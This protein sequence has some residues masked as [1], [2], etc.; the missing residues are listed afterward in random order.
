MSKVRIKLVS[1]G[2][3]PIEF[4]STKVLH[5]KSSTFEIVDDIDNYALRCDSDIAN[6]WAFSDQLVKKQLP[7]VFDA[8]FLIALVNV[9]IENNYYSRRLAN[10]QIVFTFYE[11]KEILENDNIPLEN[12]VFRILYEYTLL[13]KKSGNKIPA[14]GDTYPSFTH[15]ETRGC[16]FDMN[17]I[18]KDLIAS[19]NKPNI[20][21]ECQENLKREKVSN[22]LIRNTQKD[23]KKIKRDLYYR[24][25]SFIK[26]H[27]IMSF[28]ISATFALLLGIT[29]SVIASF[30]F[31]S[32]KTTQTHANV[33]GASNAPQPTKNI[34]NTP[35]GVKEHPLNP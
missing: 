4:Q 12:V 13:F 21:D 3:L 26:K 6:D 18:K 9:P 1:I 29:S 17:G 22:D 20:C 7:T 28:I 15:D 32:I 31:E 11:V 30:I 8:D 23:I 34:A 14:I 33:S 35:T 2:H 19:C 10:N 5:W 27:P 16:L 24:A 25:F